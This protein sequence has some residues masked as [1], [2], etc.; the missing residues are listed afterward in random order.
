MRVHEKNA[1]Q[2]VL[3]PAGTRHEGKACGEQR[4]RAGDDRLTRKS[5]SQLRR[6]G[7]RVYFDRALEWKGATPESRRSRL[8]TYMSTTVLASAALS[9]VRLSNEN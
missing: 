8:S 6:G 9:P 4:L 3:L 2:L 5:P 7:T 1:A